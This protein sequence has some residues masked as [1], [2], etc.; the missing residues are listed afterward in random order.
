[1]P[2][3]KGKFAPLTEE[4]GWDDR[5]KLDLTDL[6]RLMFLLIIHTS[7]MT[8][9]R[10][11][12]NPTYY[13]LQ[14]GVRARTHQIKRAISHI[15]RVY[16]KLSCIDGKLSLLNSITYENEKRLEVEVEVEGEREEQPKQKGILKTGP[17]PEEVKTYFTEIGYPQEAE[18]FNDHFLSNGW[19]VGGKTAMKDWKAA[20]RNWGRRTGVP[21]KKKPEPVLRPS[22]KDCAPPPKEF[23][24]LKERIGKK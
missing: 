18:K 1:M 7:H 24:S 17:K 11:P 14:Y 16:T 19:K 12:I 4:L 3:I 20:A 15:M 5:F 9:H 2:K 23:L 8:R 22:E 13:R 6:E 10:A 21:P